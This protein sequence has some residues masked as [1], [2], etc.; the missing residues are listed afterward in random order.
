MTIRRTVTMV[1]KDPAD[2]WILDAAGELLRSM[3][4]LGLRPTKGDV[5]N[6]HDGLNRRRYAT[7]VETIWENI[8]EGVH[9]TIEI[10]PK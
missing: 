7:I 8:P 4:R 1:I 3:M 9:V 6:L 2:E 10:E 5:I